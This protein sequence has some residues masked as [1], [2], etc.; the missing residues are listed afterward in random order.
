[1]LGSE[2]ASHRA[3]QKAYT[4]CHMSSLLLTLH[5]FKPS[6]I[7]IM[8]SVGAMLSGSWEDQD[9][10]MIFLGR[11]SQLDELVGDQEVITYQL[12]QLRQ[13]CW[14]PGPTHHH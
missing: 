7:V 13:D 12:I 8:G 14:G 6:S 5:M 10:L 1:M 2:G 9:H 3:P 4:M 11:P